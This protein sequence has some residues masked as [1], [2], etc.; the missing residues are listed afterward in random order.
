MFCTEIDLGSSIHI[1]SKHKLRLAVTA[2]AQVSL[3]SPDHTNNLS[4]MTL[5]EIFTSR[6][7]WVS[8]GHGLKL[9]VDAYLNG[10]IR[11]SR[12]T[13]LAFSEIGEILEHADVSYHKPSLTPLLTLRWLALVRPWSCYLTN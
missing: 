10:T 4:S 7:T 11:G 1:H 3:P 6:D 13:S 8:L 12:P 2:S 5:P 9:T